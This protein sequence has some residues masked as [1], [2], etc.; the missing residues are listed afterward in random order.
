M[1]VS[2]RGFQQGS[3]GSKNSTENRNYFF[4]PLKRVTSERMK[5]T[6]E[7]HFKPALLPFV[8]SPR[9]ETTGRILQGFS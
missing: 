2:E 1:K 3:L 4:S 6:E 9:G 7:F 5:N 8:L